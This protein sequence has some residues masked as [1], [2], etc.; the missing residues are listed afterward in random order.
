MGKKTALEMAKEAMENIPLQNKT[1]TEL[2]IEDLEAN[3][4]TLTN[5]VYSLQS[6]VTVL[7]DKINMK[8][9]K[10]K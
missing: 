1:K 5:S 6:Q 8:A 7:E 3:V 4:S 2:R 9:D 10:F